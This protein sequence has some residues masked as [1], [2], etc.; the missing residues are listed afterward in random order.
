MEQYFITTLN[1]NDFIVAVAYNANTNAE[2]YRT[3]PYAN[4]AQALEDLNNYLNKNRNTD[5]TVSAFS[6]VPIPAPVTAGGCCGR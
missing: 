1:E 2:V 5:A 4:E 3:I 6:P